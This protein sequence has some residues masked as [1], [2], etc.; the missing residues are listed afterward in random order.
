MLAK[1][2][3]MPGGMPSDGLL[4]ASTAVCPTY[5]LCSQST[6]ACPLSALIKAPQ[7]R[8]GGPLPLATSGLTSLSYIKVDSCIPRQMERGSLKMPPTLKR[9]GLEPPCQGLG[10]WGAR[11][12]SWWN[13]GHYLSLCVGQQ[14]ETTV[15]GSVLHNL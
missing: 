7:P 4:I 5:S 9:V 2:S 1:R 15:T 10:P 8:P 3:C 14:G 6:K 12:H 13:F 11:A